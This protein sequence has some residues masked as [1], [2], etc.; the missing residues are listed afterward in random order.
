MLYDTFQFDFRRS[1]FD[2]RHLHFW[3][4]PPIPSGVGLSAI[5]LAP[6][7]TQRRCGVPLPSLTETQLTSYLLHYDHASHINHLL[8]ENTSRLSSQPQHLTSPSLH[9][10]FIVRNK[11]KRR[12][13]AK[14]SLKVF[15]QFFFFVRVQESKGF[16]KQQQFL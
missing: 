8:S 12:L 9:I 11:H 13:T 3:P 5:L 14:M 10:F 4:C 15:I 2:I 16:I 7:T 6:P 1:K